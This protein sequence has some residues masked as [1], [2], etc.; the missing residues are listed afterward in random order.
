[1]DNELKKICKAAIINRQPTLF[2]HGIAAM[3]IIPCDEVEDY[4][5]RISPLA[6]APYNGDYDGDALNCFIIHD[7][8]A[9]KELNEKAHI[10]NTFRY[11]SDNKFLSV[12]RHEALQACFA[13]TEK[14][15]PNHNK[16]PIKID[17]LQ[18]LYEDFEYW[19][20]E[21]DKPVLINNECYSYGICLINKW[22]GLKIVKL[23]A[24]IT[25]DEA[26]LI[27]EAIYSEVGKDKF[28]DQLTD[29][30][31][32]LL[33]FISS[34]NHCPTINFKE[35]SEVVNS[36]TERLF[37]NLPKN[38]PYIGYH[39]NEGLV[40]RCIENLN[41][42]SD[43][44]KLYK[45]GSRLN[46]QQ[47]SRT[48]INIGYV[49]DANNIVIHEPVCS[50]LI[51]GLTKQD[52]FLTSPGAR[53]GI[54]DKADATPDSG[55][56]ER[57]MTMGFS[58]VEIAEEDCG[59]IHSLETIIFNVKHAQSLVGKY[60]KDYYDVNSDW[61]VLDLETA[62]SFINKK[63]KIRSPMTCQTPNFKIC[64]KC[65]GDRK[66]P[67]KYV[68][69]VAGQ[70]VSERIT[71]LIMRSF[72]TSGS[73]NLN[74]DGPVK[75]FIKDHLIK[76]EEDENEIRL[77]F[78]TDRFPDSIKDIKGFQEVDIDNNMIIFDHIDDVVENVDVLSVKTNVKNV[79]KTIPR[80]NK[81]PFELYGE[82]I[83]NLLTVGTPYSS[84]IEIALCN[85]F[86]SDKKELEFWRYNVDKK[87]VRKLGDKTLAVNLSSTL[88][89]LFQP[90]ERTIKNVE[91]NT[92]PE[93][94]TI[95]EKIWHEMLD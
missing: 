8:K 92:D 12:P 53:K 70:I 16:E 13:L 72:H 15:N 4:T 49:A 67:T 81:H 44:Y 85:M 28:Y 25:K 18:E 65:F 79:L 42:K 51:K 19:N 14:I 50:N 3:D 68:G 87:A 86:L 30:N 76:L 63:I 54:V 20:D 56:L 91:F 32:K 43:L 41:P 7:H 69:I 40:D 57:T 77:T 84:F 55:Y 88:G 11:D 2:R 39:I 31:K 5:M 17:N 71:Q 90:N 95:Y 35:M 74:T 62:K 24:V 34:T 21:L 29:L 23:N 27:S 75:K 6:L 48:C 82:L 93:K 9:L 33:F 89:C 78:D 45:A 66:F 58:P 36:K 47:L 52:Y 37:K 64:R 10:K 26:E 60:F 80:L 83:S 1:L 59:T 46:K 94:M 61:E 38:N 73:A 22:M